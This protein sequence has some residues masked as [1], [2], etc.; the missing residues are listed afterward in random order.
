MEEQHEFQAD[1]VVI[2]AG[3]A[4]LGAALHLVQAGL[5]VII[6]E[7]RDRI[8]GR[9]DTRE[10]DGTVIEGGAN[11]RE[12]QYGNPLDRYLSECPQIAMDRKLF[13]FFMQGKKI[14]GLETLV[15]IVKFK[16]YLHNAVAY[17][18]RNNIKTQED[19]QKHGIHSIKDLIRVSKP[20]E[21]MFRFLYSNEVPNEI[22]DVL[23]IIHDSDFGE[24]VDHLPPFCLSN[25]DSERVIF[26][27]LLQT[28]S[29]TTGRIIDEIENY[30]AQNQEEQDK[31]V[32]GGYKSVCLKI[33]DEIMSYKGQCQLLLECPVVEVNATDPGN[34]VVAFNNKNTMRQQIRC[35]RII[36]TMPFGVLRKTLEENPEF[37]KP[38]LSDSRIAALN[39]IGQ[40]LVNKVIL[41]F[42][43]VFWDNSLQVLYIKSRAPGSKMRDWVNLNYFTHK[44]PVLIGIY[45]GEEAK[46]IGKDDQAVVQAALAELRDVYG[47]SVPEP[48]CYYITHWDQDPY[49]RGSWQCASLEQ[50]PGDIYN[51]ASPWLGI[52]FAGEGCAVYGQNVHG[53]F[54]SGQ[55]TAEDVVADMHLE[56]QET[57]HI[58]SGK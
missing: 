50:L 19:L 39:R 7:A 14:T 30:S 51:F 41:K 33:L 56:L 17:L 37:I 48:K 49:S 46:F 32:L 47:D 40:G 44:D 15:L 1:V 13:G 23:S 55:Q 35:Q 58:S 6:V 57:P 4:G 27:Q 25:E 11:W 45:V 34:C 36:C 3:M 5:K 24:T 31:L 16:L 2:G 18:K 42:D 10:L 8:G 26:H 20:K 9:I 22:F 43:K 54:I 53:A 12:M 21:G 28:A 29:Y 52:F 38:T